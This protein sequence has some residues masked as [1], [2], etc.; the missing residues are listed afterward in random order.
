[1]LPQQHQYYNA[2][3]AQVLLIRDTMIFLGEPLHSGGHRHGCGH[4][5][6][7]PAGVPPRTLQEFLGLL[8]RDESAAR[9][10]LQR[11]VA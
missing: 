6:S 4:D 7:D 5:S 11:R 3:K 10:R 9:D 2:K 1:M 8:K